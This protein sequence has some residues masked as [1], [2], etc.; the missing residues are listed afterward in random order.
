MCKTHTPSVIDL[1]HILHTEVGVS[2]THINRSRLIYVTSTYPLWQ[3]WSIPKMAVPF[4]RSHFP[5][6]GKNPNTPSLPSPYPTPGQT[7][8]PDMS[9][10]E[11]SLPFRHKSATEGVCILRGSWSHCSWCVR[12]TMGCLSQPFCQRHRLNLPQ[13][14]QMGC[15][16]QINQPIA[17][18]V[19]QWW[20]LFHNPPYSLCDTLLGN[21]K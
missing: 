4:E 12:W 11:A 17:V 14:W 6:G 21:F 9:K 15:R 10:Q 1:H 13:T 3:L 8:M 18:N 19:Y 16:L 7:S 5:V 20:E 2:L